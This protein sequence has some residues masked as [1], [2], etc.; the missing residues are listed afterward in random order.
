MILFTGLPSNLSSAFQEARH[1]KLWE[2][3]KEEMS[4]TTSLIKEPMN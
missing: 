1:G 2:G 3:G 4:N